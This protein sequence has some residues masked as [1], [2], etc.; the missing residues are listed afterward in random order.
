M[1]YYNGTALANNLGFE[2]VYFLNYDYILKDNSYID[3]NF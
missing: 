1:N 3:G 2:K